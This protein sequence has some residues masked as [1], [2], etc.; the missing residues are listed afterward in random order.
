MLDK[1]AA[2]AQR[3]SG[4][5]ELRW[6]GNYSVQMSMRKGTLT[7]NTRSQS[8]G[9]SARIHRNAGFG[10]AALPVTMTTRSRQSWRR[11]QTMLGSCGR[12]P[13]RV[14]SPFPLPA[15]A[16]TIIAANMR[17]C[18]WPNASVCC[19][20]SMPLSKPDINRDLGLSSFVSEKAVANSEGAETYSYIPR[21][22]LGVTLSM[23]AN[24]GI[25]ELYD[26]FGGFG[27]FEDQFL[28]LDPILSRVEQLYQ[29]LREK[30]QGT[31][32]EAGFHDVV[33]DS[34]V[35]GILAHEAIG[36]TC[37]ADSVL[38]GSVAGDCLGEMVASEK[39]TLGDYA[40]RG[41]DGSSSFAIHVDDEGTPC[42][43]VTIIEKGVLKNFL[44]NKETA[45]RLGQEPTGNARAYSFSDEPLVR[46]R[47][48]AILPG[49]DKLEDMIGAV[50]RGYYLKR[51]TNGQADW[52]SE[53]MFGI[54][55][56]QA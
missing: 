39:I 55:L 15:K 54:N 40:G 21:A 36:H 46:M 56:L 50:E 8:R 7:A 37:E 51:A 19:G 20:N 3:A 42:Q 35:A 48:T 32:C 41:P 53:F 43:D 4:Y 10:F 45:R 44:H 28:D 24:D 13:N 16:S 38:A 27:E 18:R 1:I 29:Y 34:A 33:L 14:S 2:R 49:E 26:V 30:A 22:S 25:V 11:P 9:L 23:Q 12:L 5:T 31:Q 17:R 47:N 6:H 52:T